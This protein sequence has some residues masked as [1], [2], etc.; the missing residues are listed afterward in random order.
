MGSIPGAEPILKVLNYWEMK[1]L[2]LPC[3]RIDL[4]VARWL[5][6]M[7]VPSPEGGDV[8]IVS[9]ISIKYIDTQIKRIFSNSD[10]LEVAH[11]HSGSSSTIPS[12]MEF[13]NVGFWVEGKTGEKKL[14]EQGRKPNN[15]FNQ[16]IWTRPQ[17]WEVSALTTAPSLP[18]PPQPHPKINN[19][20][21]L[22]KYP[23][24][25]TL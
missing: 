1:V 22:V 21:W 23:L 14:S 24:Q 17:W 25:T 8:K 9:S 13:G 20:S 6:K 10:D 12:R 5:R 2:P 7:A 18:P 19:R 4:F 11:P 3:N 15:K 16:H